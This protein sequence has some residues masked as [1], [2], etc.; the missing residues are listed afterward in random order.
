MAGVNLSRRVLGAIITG[1]GISGWVLTILMTFT[2]PYSLYSD[3]ALVA[4][5]VASGVVTVLGGLLMGLWN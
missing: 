3:D 2:L 4:S 1:L 5:V